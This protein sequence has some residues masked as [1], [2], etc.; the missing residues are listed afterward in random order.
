MLGDF[1]YEEI[2]SPLPAPAAAK[3]AWQLTLDDGSSLGFRARRR[4][5]GSW[6]AAPDT[7]SLTPPR[8]PAEPRPPSRT[9]TP[10]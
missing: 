10:S 4:A 7:I 9:R 1:A 6:Q 3:D 2:I 5:Y 8:P